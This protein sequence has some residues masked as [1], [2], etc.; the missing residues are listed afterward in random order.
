MERQDFMKAFFFKRKKADPAIFDDFALEDLNT[1]ITRAKT[2]LGVD[3]FFINEFSP[4]I[5]TTPAPATKT[6]EPVLV[7]GDDKLRFDLANFNALFFSENFLFYFVCMIDHKTGA[8]FNDK[9][10]EIPYSKIKT[11]ET[12]SRFQIIDKIEHHVFEIKIVLDNLDDIVLPLRILLVDSKTEKEDYLIPED[13]VELS[14]SLK[15]FLRYKI[16]A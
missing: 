13:L 11:I 10:I 2:I 7:Y 5:V 15:A 16:K 3:D 14:S 1:T 4:I 9:S 12:S 8:S 6:F